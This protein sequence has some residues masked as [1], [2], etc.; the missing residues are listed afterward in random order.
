MDATPYKRKVIRG[1][2][3]FPRLLGLVIAGNGIGYLSSLVQ[4]QGWLCL[5]ILSKGFM[6]KTGLAYFMSP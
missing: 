1:V 6:V 3:R 4:E 2:E 5:V